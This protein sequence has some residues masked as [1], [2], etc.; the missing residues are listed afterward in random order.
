M[1]NIFEIFDSQNLGRVN[2]NEILW[3]FSMAI[4]GTGVYA[5]QVTQTLSICYEVD[6]KLSWLFKLYDKDMNGEI[7]LMK[8]LATPHLLTGD[9]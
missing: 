5:G 8:C 3:I 4:N 9:R 7:T 1:K 2:H 6:E